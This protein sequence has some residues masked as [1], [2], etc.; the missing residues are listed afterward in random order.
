M[1]KV[2]CSE[3]IK[4]YFDSLQSEV[5]KCYAIAK[6]ARKEGYDPELNVEILQAE[7]LASRVEGLLKD[8]DVKGV[9]K[10]IREL[11]KKHNREEVSLLVAKEVARKHSRFK[12]K[13]LEIAIRVGLAII[14]EGVLVA[15]LEGVAKVKIMKNSDDSSYVDIHYAGPI[16][17]AGGTGQA[18]SILIAD[19]VRRE[20]GIGLYNPTRREIERYKEEIS[21]YEQ[22]QHLQYLPSP[23]EIDVIVRNCPVC[24]D[25]EGTE[26]AE[27]SGNRDL[28]RIDTNRVRGGA[29]LVIAEGLCQKAP[30]IQKHVKKLGI[31]GWEFITKYL[32]IKKEEKEEIEPSYNFIKDIVAGRPVLSHPSRKGGFRLRYGRTRA[33]GLAALAIHPATMYILNE[34]IAIG[35]QIKIER[36][37][38]AA[39]VTPCDSIDGPIVL[40][41]NGDL[42]GVNSITQAKKLNGKIKKIIDL[43]EI[44]VPFGEFIENNH[45]LMP[46]A[47]SIE[48]YVEELRVK[49]DKA[50]MDDMNYVAPSPQKAFELS[51]KYDV[52]LHPNYNL[53]WHD[54][55]PEDIRTLSDFIVKNGR[56]EGEILYIKKENDIKRILIDLGVL[57]TEDEG[58]FI[59]THYAYPLLRCLGL[60]FEDGPITEKKRISDGGNA[61]EYISKL[62]GIRIREKAPT[63]IGARMG[64]PEKAKERKMRPPPHVLFPLGQAGGTQ[65]LVKEASKHKKMS[66]EVGIRVCTVCKKRWFLPKCTCGGHTEL[67][68]RPVMQNISMDEILSEAMTTLGEKRMA[69]IKGVQGMI[70]KS[71]TPEPLEKGIIRAKYDVFVFK[72]GTT[73]FDMTDLPITHFKP[74][75]IGLGLSKAKELGY[76]HDVDDKPLKNKEQILELKPHDIVPSRT[77]GVYLV[78]VAK[79]LDEL[80][81]NLYGL[82]AFY[83]AKEPEDLIGH[84]LTGLAPHTSGCV[85]ARVIGYTN[86]QA[87][88]AHPFFHA[89]KRRN[90]DGDEDCVM[91]LLDGLINFS[92]SF[93]PEKRGGLMDAPLVL[94]TRIDPNEIDKEAHNLDIS[95]NYPLEFYESALKHAH[96]KEVE[97]MIDTVAKR[98]GTVGQY[99]GFK[100]THS[101]TDIAQGPIQSAYKIGS[102]I[103]KMN[104]QLDLA[105]RIRAVDERDVVSK[106]IGSHFLPDLIGNLRT[107]SSQQVRCTKCNAK[108]RRIPLAGICIKK[109]SN[110]TICG[111]NLTLTV[112]EGSVKKY[113]EISKKI[114]IEYNVSNYTK[115]RLELI[116]NA[117]QSLF[118][119]DK[120]KNCKLSDFM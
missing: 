36:P 32:S 107:F 56:Y 66:V 85:L 110:G 8:W 87:G 21:L 72:D 82:K 104:G 62:S 17:S 45:V 39:A 96:P 116:E 90:C 75:E 58:N 44:L 47:Y 81:S 120:V 5:D 108:Y 60:S 31:D 15:P 93:L 76:T 1:S 79:F 99:E 30:K 57:H 105:V 94:T 33:T 18:M 16:R 117:I 106:L 68:A 19:V 50:E 63:R 24:I 4:Q 27:I 22:V 25:G 100:F 13:A 51:E 115:Q 109:K 95:S 41:E 46:A 54:I 91:L 64:R 9:A 59:I 112:H 37:G 67:R 10:R 70:S 61:I 42:I 7:D 92:R 14:T 43:G 118:N 74:S 83:N 71:K 78:K 97:S 113:L 65:R 55:T 103:K 53:F 89:A 3:S 86:A 98:V 80:L 119:N 35:T 40:L 2:E 38:K 34:F 49:S 114:S 101:T 29:C 28:P 102:M 20:L 84:L 11:S 48:W 23:E 88:Y 12:E 73:R 69:N 26:E 111:N 52:P 6:E 77:C